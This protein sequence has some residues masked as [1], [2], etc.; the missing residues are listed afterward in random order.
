VGV[1]LLVADQ[2][3]KAWVRG[4]FQRP[5]ESHVIIRNVLDLTLVY[6]KGIAFGMFQ[7]AG[8][9]LAPIAII[10]AVAA[11]YYSMKHRDESS[12]I[13]TAMALLASGALGNLIDRVF[14]HKVT[15]MFQIRAFEFP[16]FNLADSC[17]T[18]AAVILVLRWGYEW[19]AGDGHDKPITVAPVEEDPPLPMKPNETPIP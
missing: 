5:E 19:I 9:L 13:H 8:V 7:G 10:I 16:A 3:I 12:W 6:N 14:V 1:V 11:G 4:T 18:I 2:I 17:I 15:D